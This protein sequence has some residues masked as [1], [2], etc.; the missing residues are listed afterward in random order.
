MLGINAIKRKLFK[1]RKIMPKKV[2]KKDLI[3]ESETIQTIKAPGGR[4]HAIK[5]A[6]RAQTRLDYNGTGMAF[7]GVLRIGETLQ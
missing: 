2:T 7:C 5:P 1:K 6:K 3:K 4:L